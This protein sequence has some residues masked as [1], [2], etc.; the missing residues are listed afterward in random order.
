VD[1]SRTHGADTWDL[2]AA[3]PG[4]LLGLSSLWDPGLRPVAAVARTDCVAIPV[5]RA[6]LD[7]L[8]AE[9]PTVADLLHEEAAHTAVRRLKAGSALVAD[10]ERPAGEVNRESLVRLAGAL[11]EWSVPLPRKGR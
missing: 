7:D 3:G 9:C 6:R 8:G 4:T 1:L 2:T 11:T 10:A 5:A